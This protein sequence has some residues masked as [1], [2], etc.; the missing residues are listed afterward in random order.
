MREDFVPFWGRGLVGYY[1][2]SLEGDNPG[3]RWMSA[4]NSGLNTSG[5]FDMNDAFSVRCIQS[6]YTIEA[7]PNNEDFGSVTGSGDDF[8]LFQTVTLTAIPNTGYHFQNWTEEGDE[9]SVNQEYTFS[10]TGDR[11]LVANLATNTYT[12]TASAGE[13]GSIDPVGVVTIS[14]LK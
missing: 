10:L 3:W 2:Q 8:V 9:V 13:Y 5:S 7:A 12:I 11:T 1:W 4:L 14:H 6:I